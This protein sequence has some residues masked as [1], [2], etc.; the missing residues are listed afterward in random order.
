MSD[1]TG[2]LKQRLTA[3]DKALLWGFIH[4]YTEACGG[5]TSRRTISEAREDAVAAVENALELILARC[6]QP[7]NAML[8]TESIA[9]AIQVIC[10]NGGC[11]PDT[12]CTTGQKCRKCLENWL[13]NLQATHTT[14]L[15]LT[16]IQPTDI[17]DEAMTPE[18]QRAYNWAKNQKYTSVAAEYARILA[19]VVDALQARLASFKSTGLTPEQIIKLRDGLPVSVTFDIGDDGFTLAVNRAFEA[20]YGMAADSMAE[21]LK[22]LQAQ[23][24]EHWKREQPTVEDIADFITEQEN[25]LRVAMDSKDRPYLELLIRQ[26]LSDRAEKKGKETDH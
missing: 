1:N 25:C 18:Q 22:K 6:A 12:D 16:S 15:V 3:E 17:K 8:T 9:S 13:S 2:A 23:L 14:P 19:G 26:Y 10:E 5:D 21:E 11:P 4:N 20:K 24:S 7:A